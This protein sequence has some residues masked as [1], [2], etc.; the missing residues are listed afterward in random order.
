MSV[1]KLFAKAVE[2]WPGK[3]LSLGLAIFLFV[4]HRMSTLETRSLFVPIAVERLGAMMPSSPYP[5]MVRISLRGEA[6][7]IDSILEGDIEVF[8]DMGGFDVPGAYTVP[9]QWRKKGTA[10][11][12]EPLQISVDPAEITFSLDH[13]TSKFIPLAANITGQVEDGFNM[14]SFSLNPAQVFVDG[15]AELMNTISELRTE[16]IDLS[17]RRGDFF[18]TANI[19]RFDPLVVIRGGGTAE[20]H[21]AISRIIA[22]RNVANVPIEVTGLGEGLAAELETKAAG[23]HFEGDSEAAINTFNPP[24]GFLSVDCSG[25]GAP[26]IYV[27]KVLAGPEENIPGGFT[28]RVDPDEVRIRISRPDEAEEE[29]P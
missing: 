21:A 25:I 19:L 27:L 22:V 4:F 24:S 2:N 3:V 9:V 8:A 16:P 10:L 15:P 1:S 26:G 5:P 23:I 18:L 29:S 13:K 20:F 7:S 17:G 6:E 14:T 11:G 12:A 28:Y